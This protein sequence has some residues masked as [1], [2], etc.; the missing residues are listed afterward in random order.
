MMQIQYA[1]I[2][3]V[4]IKF[5]CEEEN[6]RSIAFPSRNKK[7]I[8]SVSLEKIKIFKRKNLFI[9]FFFW[10]PNY[11]YIFY[12]NKDKKCFLY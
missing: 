7:V 1:L 11:I 10:Y 6:R 3:F 2:M 5:N 12:K 9:Y 4:I 8:I